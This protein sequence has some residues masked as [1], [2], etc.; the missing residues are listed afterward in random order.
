MGCAGRSEWDVY[1]DLT[2]MTSSLCRR[3]SRCDPVQSVSSPSSGFLQ[4]LNLSQAVCVFYLVQ[5]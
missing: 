2:E 3:S 5:L 4:N 1:I